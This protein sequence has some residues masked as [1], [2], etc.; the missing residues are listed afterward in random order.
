MNGFAQ[1]EAQ[2]YLHIQRLKELQGEWCD[3]VVGD[4]DED[5]KIGGP[6]TAP[7]KQH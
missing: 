7:M 5:T 6:K 4:N 1:K 3:E 2:G